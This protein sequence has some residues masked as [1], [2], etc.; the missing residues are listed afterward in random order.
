[1]KLFKTLMLSVVALGT[2]AF[3]SCTKDDDNN[4]A[5][6]ATITTNIDGTLTT[7][8]KTFQVLP[9]L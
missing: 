3:S 9:V 1:M 6:S 5:A 7:F 8:D 4:V 2:V